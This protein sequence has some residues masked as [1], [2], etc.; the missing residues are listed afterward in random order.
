MGDNI[1][2]I[3]PMAMGM[4][5]NGLMLSGEFILTVNDNPVIEFRAV[6]RSTLWEKNG[7]RLYYEVK[8]R[9][10]SP[11]ETCGHGKAGEF[12]GCDI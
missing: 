12:W 7:C 10:S 6:K 3:F 4:G 9:M 5:R 11:F 2:V 1:L 8:R